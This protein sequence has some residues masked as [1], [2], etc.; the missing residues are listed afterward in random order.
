LASSGC[1]SPPLLLA[2]PLLSILIFAIM[3]NCKYAHSRPTA[4]AKYIK[5]EQETIYINATINERKQNGF[6][7]YIA[8]RSKQQRKCLKRF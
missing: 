6:S 8:I 3:V 1:P 4:T 2:E 5:P 7:R